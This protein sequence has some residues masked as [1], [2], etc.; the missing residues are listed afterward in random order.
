LEDL[1][2]ENVL[3]IWSLICNI[4]RPLVIFIGHWVIL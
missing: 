4:V 1:G 2:M 3:N